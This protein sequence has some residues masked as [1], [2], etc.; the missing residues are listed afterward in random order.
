MT[1]TNHTYYYIAYTLYT[2][3]TASVAHRPRR[4][5]LWGCPP[6]L[7]L[8]LLIIIIVTMIIVIV[9]IMMNIILNGTRCATATAAEP[10]AS[11]WI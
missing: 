8:L 6:L 9:M 11:A 2:L 7:L 10:T 4:E 3:M 5:L 1:N